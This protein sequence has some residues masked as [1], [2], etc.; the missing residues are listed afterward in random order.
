MSVN[1]YLRDWAPAPREAQECR[2]W[3]E[4]EPENQVYVYPRPEQP[5][6]AIY[7]RRAWYA[8]L[9]RSRYRHADGRYSY[10]VDIDLEGIASDSSR[11]FWYD[12]EA[13]IRLRW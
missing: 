2:P 9:A 8:C 1:R 3:R 11:H 12:D 4:G 5:W 13:V 10:M 7:Y 6:L